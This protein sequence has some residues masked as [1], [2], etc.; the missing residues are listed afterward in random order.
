M[1]ITHGT[2]TGST[3]ITLAQS[4][5]PAG[6]T[7]VD[8]G[9]ATF[10]LTGTWPPVGTYTYAVTATNAFGSATS[11]GNRLISTAAG[12]VPVAP[13]AAPFTDTGVAG[14]AI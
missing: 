2:F 3:P 11:T 10:T 6:V 1:S 7:F 9:N 5:I 13:A 8:N 4:G 12:V 14:A